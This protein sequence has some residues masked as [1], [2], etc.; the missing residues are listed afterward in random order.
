MKNK[1]QKNPPKAHNH[2]SLQVGQPVK[3]GFNEALKDSSKKILC[4]CFER[5]VF[6]VINFFVNLFK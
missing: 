6:F 4:F 1:K 2:C 3:E 5:F